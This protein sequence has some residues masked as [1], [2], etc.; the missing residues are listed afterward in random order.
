MKIAVSASGQGLDAP[1]SPIFGRSQF[2]VLVDT[3][4]MDCETLAN[5]AI[6]AAGGAG[7]QA[8]QFLVSHGVQALVSGNVG[9]NAFQV[10]AA[11]DVPVYL[12]SGST[13]GEAVDAFAK[14][15]LTQASGPS[16]RSHSGLGGGGG[17]G[18]GQG[19]RH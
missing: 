1:A 9:P 6:S 16:A 7:I 14:G 5:P 17:Q 19:R 8:A 15:E 3:E 18:R 12:F 11:A 10:F 13:V 2:M 4:T